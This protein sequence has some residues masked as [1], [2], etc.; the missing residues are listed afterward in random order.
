MNILANYLILLLHVV[1]GTVVS[2]ILTVRNLFFH[3]RLVSYERDV[4]MAQKVIDGDTD[5]EMAQNS[6][7]FLPR[8]QFLFEF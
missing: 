2:N 5:F 7:I 8:I 1:A 4:E 3:L 6:N